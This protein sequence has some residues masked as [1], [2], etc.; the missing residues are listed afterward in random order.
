MKSLV[1]LGLAVLSAMPEVHAQTSGVVG[2]WR[3]PTGSVIRIA[4]CGNALCATL[5]LVSSAAPVRV[6][7]NNPDAALR[8]RPLCGLQIGQGFR[9]S[10]P[11]RAEGGNLY[12]PK[13]GKTYKG[14]MTSEGNTL[15]LRGYIGISLFGRTAKWQRV[16]APVQGCTA[17]SGTATGKPPTGV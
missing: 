13:N 4:S 7:V 8:T 3:E 10:D 17:G 9:A 1:L 14:N 12:D 2:D 15:L 16:T 11:N 5:V 6:D